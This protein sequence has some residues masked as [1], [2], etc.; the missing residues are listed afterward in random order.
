MTTTDMPERQEPALDADEATMLSGWLE[1]HRETLA[2]KCSGLTDE[3]L[4]TASV[5]PSTLCL[6][7]LMR[8]MSEVEQHWF[9]NVFGGNSDGPYYFTDEDP[10]GDFHPGPEATQAE[11]LATWRGEV[12]NS[13]AHAAGHGLDEMSKGTSRNGSH[14]S[15]RWI[16]THM[17][18]EYARHNGHADLLRQA[19]DGSTGD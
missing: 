19:V 16:Y 14:F 9:A 7:G 1:Y 10:D 8:H 6:M 12:A 18:E 4:R 5:P 15:L 13:R 3:Q 17:I 2:A 11:A